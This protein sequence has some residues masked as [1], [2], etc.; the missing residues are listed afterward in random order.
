MLRLNS[1]ARPGLARKARA[2]TLSNRR[3]SSTK[4]TG[5]SLSTS[6]GV[7]GYTLPSGD[8]VPSVGLGTWRMGGD[9]AGEAVKVVP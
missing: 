4:G 1:V 5:P 6:F 9:D 7:E 8:T 3:I 2:T